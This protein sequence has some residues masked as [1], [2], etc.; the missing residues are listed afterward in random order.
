M[1]NITIHDY[2]NSKNK[3]KI[4][5][6]ISR[7]ESQFNGLLNW[8]I[9]LYD[10]EQKGFFASISSL[11]DKKRFYCAVSNTAQALNILNHLDLI[12]TMPKN[13]KKNFINFFSNRQD[14]ADGFFKDN[15]PNMYNNINNLGRAYQYAIASLK[16]LNAKPKYKLKKDN[17]V[18]EKYPELASLEKFKNW[19]NSLDFDDPYY[20]GNELQQSRLPIIN[21]LNKNLKD[22]ILN[23]I[24]V[25]LKKIQSKK[26]GYWGEKPDKNNYIYLSG[27][28]KISWF[29]LEFFK[30]IPK[31]YLIFKSIRDLLQNNHK[32][33]KQSYC[34]VRNPLSLLQII[35]KFLIEKNNEDDI[36]S[37]IENSINHSLLF[38]QEDGG[39]SR[40][41]GSSLAKDL[42]QELSLGLK[43][44][45]LN[46]SVQAVH[47]LRPFCYDAFNI[48][49][50]K[51]NGYKDFYSKLKYSII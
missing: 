19:F 47:T 38:L 26:T 28:Y 15:D 48:K 39:F 10:K 50:P 36:I 44:G 11:S 37:I 13:F 20:I 16:M 24:D 35:D 27:A 43:E 34:F 29:Y 30:E 18:F 12:K 14:L 21:G 22:S 2:K 46:A 51:I 6:L 9:K 17:T 5:F 25:K 4:L 42:D 3:Q 49:I 23:I 41:H 32:D 45:D 40:Q 1:K 8:L 7:L 33:V 31:A